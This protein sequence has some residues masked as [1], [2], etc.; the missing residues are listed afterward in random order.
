MRS[1]DHLSGNRSFRSHRR[2]APPDVI[3]IDLL[4]PT[5]EEKAFVESRANVRIPSIE[6]LSEIEASSRLSVDGDTVYLSVPAVAHSDTADAHL[7]PAGLILTPH[8][9]ITVRFLPAPP[10]P[11][12]GG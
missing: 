2:H 3:W 5:D 7:T 8:L 6:S 1:A 11:R 4:N 12:R 10:S 9:L